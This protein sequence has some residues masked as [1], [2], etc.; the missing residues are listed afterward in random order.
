MTEQQEQMIYDEGRRRG[1][2]DGYHACKDELAENVMERIEKD[3]TLV[4]T[5][6]DATKVTRVLVQDDMTNGNLYYVDQPKSGLDENDIRRIAL[7]AIGEVDLWTDIGTVAEDNV[8][9]RRTMVIG[10]ISGITTL[11]DEL[12]RQ[13]KQTEE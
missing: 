12:V 7:E 13:I 10:Y 8:L 4:V 3:G 2:N 9:D 1:F 6:S 11:A 5:I